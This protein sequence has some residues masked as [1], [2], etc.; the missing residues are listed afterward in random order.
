MPSILYRSDDQIRQAAEDLLDQYGP[1]ILIPV[2]VEEI[3]EIHLGLEIIPFRAYKQRFGAD[4]S[5]STDL[6]NITV[7]EES[8]DRYA[9]RYHFTLAH[10]VGHLLLH[11]DYIQSLAQ[12]EVADWKRAILETSATDRSRM[13]YQASQF[14]G[15]LLVP[16][17]PLV[18]AFQEARQGLEDRGYDIAELSD[19]GISAISRVIAPQ[20]E[21]SARVVDI[22]L[23]K[24][25]LVE[26]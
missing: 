15:C 5:I 26:G 18:T 22:R 2:P 7:D 11:A 17:T 8:M 12:E 25:G 10:E 6:T 1:D 9:N 3:V 20:F 16:R 19:V 23:R 14:A 21:V 13:E 4:G 24:E